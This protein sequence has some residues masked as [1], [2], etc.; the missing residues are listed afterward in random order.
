MAFS[1]PRP[2]VQTKSVVLAKDLMCG[3]LSLTDKN[4]IAL[5]TCGCL[6][7]VLSDPIFDD[8]V[9]GVMKE[10]LN[11]LCHLRTII[12]EANVRLFDETTTD[13]GAT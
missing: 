12:I 9:A 3:V 7:W 13:L 1:N 5:A 11:V 4:V 2:I 6:P 8:T 10:F